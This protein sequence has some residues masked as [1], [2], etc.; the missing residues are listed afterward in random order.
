[1]QADHYA[2]ARKLHIIL[3]SKAAVI[4]EQLHKLRII[5]IH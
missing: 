1:M 4:Y 3:V 2:A 5:N